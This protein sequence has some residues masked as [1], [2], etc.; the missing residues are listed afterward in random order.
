[1]P[2]TR[3]SIDSGACFVIPNIYP[4]SGNDG[5][6]GNV[7]YTDDD[8]QE[9]DGLKKIMLVYKIYRSF[10]NFIMHIINRNEYK[11]PRHFIDLF[12]RPIPWLFASGV[13]MLIFDKSGTNLICNPFN[14]IKRSKYVI[15]IQQDEL[16]FVPVYLFNISTKQ[17]QI[18]GE[19]DINSVATQVAAT[20]SVPTASTVTAFDW[21]KDD[22][23]TAKFLVKTAYG[24][25]TDVAEVILTLDTSDNI[26]ITEYAMVGTNGSAMTISADVSANLVRLRVA[27]VNNNSVVTVVGT[28][29]A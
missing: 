2:I 1:M 19:I 22:Y 18:S 9:V 20:T 6:S 24:S 29:L 10:Y 8:M 28:L 7:E 27:T 14:N 16:V 13:N 21:A 25:H 12:C 3:L 4:I 17:P 15:L 11:D 23:R 26:A 5:N